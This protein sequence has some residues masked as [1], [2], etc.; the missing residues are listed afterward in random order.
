MTKEEQSLIC[1]WFD[2]LAQ[3]ADDHKTNTGEIMDANHCFAEM[4]RLAINASNF[5]KKFGDNPEA[6]K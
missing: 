6:F 5:I 2:H 3:L 4:Y 1:S